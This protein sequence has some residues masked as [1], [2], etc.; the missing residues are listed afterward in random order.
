MTRPEGDQVPLGVQGDR[1]DRGWGQALHQHLGLEAWRKW[2][3][4]QAWLQSVV[5]LPGEALPVLKQ[6]NNGH[7]HRVVG[8]LVVQTQNYDLD[9]FK[10]L[11]QFQF[12]MTAQQIWPKETEGVD[13]L[14]CPAVPATTS[15]LLYLQRLI[16]WM[17][18]L[19][20]S[21]YG[22]KHPTCTQAHTHTN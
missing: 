20:S 21:L 18:S 13:A 9:T 17:P 16:F 12:E 1:C 15:L 8:A 19:G 4:L 7:L 11:C 14:T 3:G 5:A 6:I 2:G 10:N 22:S